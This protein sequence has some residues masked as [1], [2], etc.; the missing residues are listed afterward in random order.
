MV[1]CLKLGCLLKKCNYI[2]IKA[3]KKVCNWFSCSVR[4]GQNIDSVMVIKP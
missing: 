3:C 2:D 4:Y 1:V